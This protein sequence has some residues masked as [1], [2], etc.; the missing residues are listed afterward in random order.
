M[1]FDRII[2]AAAALSTFALIAPN[3]LAQGDDQCFDKATLSYVDCPMAPMAAPQKAWYITAFGGAA[4]PMDVDTD[5]AFV[6]VPFATVDIELDTGF[7]AGGAIGTRVWHGHGDAL[8]A[9]LELSYQSFDAANADVAILAGGGLTTPLSGDASTM[10]L[11]MNLWYDVDT[12]S[13]FT[14][15]LGGGA[16]LA[17]TDV[18]ISVPG[19]GALS[20]VDEDT[21]FAFQ[22]GA[23]VNY[24]LTEAIDLGV[25]YRFRAVTDISVSG[26][27]GGIAEFS[28]GELYT[29]GVQGNVTL[30]F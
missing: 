21:S 25:G 10:M 12:G 9:E 4:I 13:A 28:D 20:V 24:A 19:L 2:A 18:D 15:Y 7:L 1:A 8:R 17:F 23:G 5:L 29:H 16:G 27:P 3:A 26:L 22:L 30:N 14:P 6:G 11:L